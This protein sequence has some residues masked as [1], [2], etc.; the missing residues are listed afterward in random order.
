ME[1]IGQRHIEDIVGS[2]E[3]Y[4]H[5]YDIV[6]LSWAEGFTV[7]SD[8]AR[9]YADIVGMAASM[10][11][12]TTRVMPGVYSSSWQVTLEG[13]GWLEEYEEGF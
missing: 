5:L 3:L 11:L 12:I 9:K 2:E 4:E 6:K 10:G 1:E 8:V 7:K 13:Q